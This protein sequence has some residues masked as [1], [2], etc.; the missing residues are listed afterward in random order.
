[1]NLTIVIH[2]QNTK[3]IYIK[4][5]F[6]LEAEADVEAKTET[7]TEVTDMGKPILG[8]RKKIKIQIK[9]SKVIKVSL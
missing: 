9:E 1:V 4:N 6:N 8:E 3:Q 2:K 5:L 7:E